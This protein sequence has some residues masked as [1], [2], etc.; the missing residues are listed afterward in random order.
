M[1]RQVPLLWEVLLLLLLFW[2]PLQ[3]LQMSSAL[4]DTSYSLTE[5]KGTSSHATHIFIPR[6]ITQVHTITLINV[7]EPLNGR[8]GWDRLCTVWYC[9]ARRR[10][11][12]ETKPL[13]AIML[14]NPIHA[15]LSILQI[16]ASQAAARRHTRTH[17]GTEPL[18]AAHS[19]ALRSVPTPASRQHESPP[20]QVI[21]HHISRQARRGLDT[22][23][24]SAHHSDQPVACSARMC[25][26]ATPGIHNTRAAE[27]PQAASKLNQSSNYPTGSHGLEK[28][29]PSHIA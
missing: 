25:S 17:S 9:I 13:P 5:N 7:R 19:Q 4:R 23:S 6:H 24:N 18:G 11:K 12:I 28:V 14:T 1:S 15:C 26:K 16:D 3:L 10:H 8:H 22:H 21:A 2:L 29:L 20:V 27:A